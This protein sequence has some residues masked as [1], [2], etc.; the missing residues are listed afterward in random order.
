GLRNFF[1]KYSTGT[2]LPLPQDLYKE[3]QTVTPDSMQYLLKDLFATNTY[4]EFKTEKAIASQTSSGKWKV[5][6]DVHARKYTVD[7]NGTQT[8][9]EMNDW[10]QIGVNGLSGGTKADKNLYMQQ[11][12]IRSGMQSIEIEVTGK[13]ALAGIDPNNLLMD[14]ENNDNVSEVK[15][16]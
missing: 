9:V 10:I 16:R 2:A 7:K 15:L 6:M 3:L 4:W 8:D 5:T 1:K 12:R 14:F 11:H 13:P